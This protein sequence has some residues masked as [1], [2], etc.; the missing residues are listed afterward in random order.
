MEQS[1]AQL[2]DLM[3]SLASPQ[4]DPSMEPPRFQEMRSPSFPLASATSVSRASL[5]DPVFVLCLARSGSTLLRFLLDAHQDLACPPETDLAAMCSQLARTWSLLAGTQL[6]KDRD[7]T[8]PSVPEPV[9]TG[10]RNAVNQMIGQHLER[11]GKRRYCDKSM[12]TARHA[13][14]MLQLFPGVK[15]ICLYR[16]P[17]DV[18]ASGIEA[19]PWGLKGFGFDSYAADS[20]NNSVLALARFWADHTTAIRSV[21]ER[22]PERC[23]RVRY[24]DLVADPEAT[25]DRIFRFLGVP[26][27]PGVSAS[28]FTPDRERNGPG[29]YKIWQTSRITADSQGRGWSIPASL[30]EPAVIDAVNQLADSLGYVR[31]DERWSVADMPPDLRL[32][33][34]CAQSAFLRAGPA[35]STRQMPRAYL[36][37]GDLL[38]AGL[39]RVSKRFARRWAAH[40][41]ESFLVIATSPGDVGVA[42]W[43]VDLAART[44][45][46]VDASKGDV[47]VAGNFSW[48]I[49]GSASTWERV[50]AGTANLNV[51]LRRRELR[52]CDT[53]TTAVTIAATRTTMLADLLGI[54]SWRSRE[55]AGRSDAV[56]AA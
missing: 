31:V 18:I 38:Q 40:A 10:V 39:F 45:T 36:V 30:I 50:I 51:A 22:F 34:S 5:G 52:Y 54:T 27:A 49:T 21:E 35:D 6:L 4:P 24:E 11:R 9:L 29:D 47:G 43:R 1:A 26:S 41:A 8:V 32:P 44:V 12:Y 19:C 56:P 20:P 7:G 33:G 17:M 2:L 13:D 14:L 15:F 48:Q 16:H 46:L 3:R 42:R 25:T 23:H 53:G 37:L 55:T 28:C